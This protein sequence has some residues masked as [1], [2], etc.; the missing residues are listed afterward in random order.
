MIKGV[1]VTPCRAL[2][3]KS[4]QW[5]QSQ[6]GTVS[7]VPVSG[8]KTGLEIHGRFWSIQSGVHIHSKLLINGLAVAGP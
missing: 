7:G 2:L 8:E 4:P 6:L 1:G 3:S 5:L